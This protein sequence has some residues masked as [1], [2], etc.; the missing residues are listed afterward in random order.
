MAKQIII[1]QVFKVFGDAPEQA[2]D[3]VRQGLGK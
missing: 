1:D 3:L 2:M